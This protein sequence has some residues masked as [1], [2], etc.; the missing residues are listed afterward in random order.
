LDHW[1][2]V[3]SL[4]EQCTRPTIAAVHGLALAGGLELT[5]ACDVVVATEDAEFGD[6]HA[7]F[8]LFPGG[9]STQ[10]L[11]RLVGR[12]AATWVLLSGD[13]VDASTA[14]QLGLGDR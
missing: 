6:Q 5:Q 4:V 3:L 9:G 7:K 11:P 1:H 12:R 14:P 10:R 2:R 8:G 13:P